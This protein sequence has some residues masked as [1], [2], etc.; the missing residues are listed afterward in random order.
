VIT[1]LS[2]GFSDWGNDGSNGRSNG[3]AERDSDR[4]ADYTGLFWHRPWLAGVFTAMLLSLAGIPLTMGFI[5]KF[6][7]LTAGVEASLWIPV[8]ALVV[9]SIIGLFYYLRIIAVMCAPASQAVAEPI[10]R[11]VAPSFGESVPL[12]ALALLLIWLG[13]FPAQLIDVLE[14]TVVT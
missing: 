9:G 13:I 5:G 10:M 3:V 1:V 7:I 14:G 11:P 4:L 6:Y 12:A 2:G 8:I